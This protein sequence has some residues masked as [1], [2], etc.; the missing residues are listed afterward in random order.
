MSALADFETFQTTCQMTGHAA[1][2]HLENL[3]RANHLISLTL[4]F[5][6]AISSLPGLLKSKPND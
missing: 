6:Y 5:S 2:L 4:K 1:E 3:Y